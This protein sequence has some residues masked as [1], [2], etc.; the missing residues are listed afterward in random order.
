MIKKDEK[1]SQNA[2]K[3]TTLIIINVSLI[4]CI[5]LSQTSPFINVGGFPRSPLP[6][7]LTDGC[8]LQREKKRQ[9]GK[10]DSSRY[11]EGGSGRRFIVS[12]REVVSFAL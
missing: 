7:G 8:L 3:T 12:A 2:V 1:F 10:L 9:Q 4:K 5:P 6:L 11:L